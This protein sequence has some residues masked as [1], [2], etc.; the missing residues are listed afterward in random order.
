MEPVS[1]GGSLAEKLPPLVFNSA[2]INTLKQS[3]P[4]F[5]GPRSARLS[6]ARAQYSKPQITLDTRDI[7][8]FAAMEGWPLRSKDY[9]P[10]FLGEMRCYI[11]QELG[12]LQIGASQD[13]RLQIFREV[14]GTEGRLSDQ[15]ANIIQITSSSTS[16][17]ISLFSLR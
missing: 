15:I 14:F 10:K 4:Q 8:G 11:D 1:T 16:V 5:A 9:E 6:T 3:L 2:T 12:K 13:A 7:S 17:C